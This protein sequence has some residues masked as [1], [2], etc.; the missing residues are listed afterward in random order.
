MVETAFFLSER[1]LLPKVEQIYNIRNFMRDMIRQ[2]L[3]LF[4][5]SENQGKKVSLSL[6]FSLIFVSTTEDMHN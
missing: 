2:I 3:I 1:I 4:Y 5:P 6:T